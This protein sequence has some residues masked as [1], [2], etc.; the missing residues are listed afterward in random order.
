MPFMLSFLRSCVCYF[1]VM[2]KIAFFFTK[3]IE[4][5]AFKFPPKLVDS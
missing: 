5:G 3:G 1:V 4:V 2:E